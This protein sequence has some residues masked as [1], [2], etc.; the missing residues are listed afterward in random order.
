MRKLKES[1]PNERGELKATEVSTR[2]LTRIYDK[3]TDRSLLFEAKTAVLRT[4]TYGDKHEDVYRHAMRCV[5]RER[6]TAGH[7]IFFSKGLQ[8][9]GLQIKGPC[10]S[11]QWR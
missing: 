10:G 11:N 4:K 8:I 7:L 9:K 3:A 2:K 1:K 6:E 5:S